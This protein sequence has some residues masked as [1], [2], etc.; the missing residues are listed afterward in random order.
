[1]LD[2]VLEFLSLSNLSTS[3]IIWVVVGTF[4]QLTFFSRW[5]VQLIYSEKNKSSIIPVGFWWLSLFGGLI[6]FI[7]AK[8]INSFPFMLA[9]GVGIL[10]YSRNLY[11]VY[12]KK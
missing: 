10:V 1:M 2:T 9:Q 4:G 11:L 8:H 12:Y 5:V 7:Y 6:T 3:E